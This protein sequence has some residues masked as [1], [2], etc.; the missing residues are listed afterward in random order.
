MRP[1]SG[2]STI[3]WTRDRRP[4]MKLLRDI[5]RFRLMIAPYVLEILFWAGI[6]GTL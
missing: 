2:P 3:D 5:L 1:H 6:G 4:T